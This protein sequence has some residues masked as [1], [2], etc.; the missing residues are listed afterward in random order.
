[1]NRTRENFVYEVALVVCK[2][3]VK[4]RINISQNLQQTLCDKSAPYISNQTVFSTLQKTKNKN[5][6]ILR[7]KKLLR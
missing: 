7:T 5:I 3:F 4:I 1:M 2:Y 6:N